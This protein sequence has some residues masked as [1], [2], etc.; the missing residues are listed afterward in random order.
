MTKR[1]VVTGSKYYENYEEAKGY[2]DRCIEN[3]KDGNTLIFAS[4]GCAG[5][6]TLAERYAN[7]MG[8]KT[9]RYP[10]LWETYGSAGGAVRNRQML[11]SSDLIICFWD[12]TIGETCS[13]TMYAE[14]IGKEVKTLRVHK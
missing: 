6:E 3:I 8:Y 1:I 11:D 2:I 4:C 14:L 10:T 9:E 12:G 7:E 13:M 5:A